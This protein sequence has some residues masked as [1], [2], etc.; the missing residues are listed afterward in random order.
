M[1]L[2]QQNLGM[3]KKPSVCVWNIHD[4][5]M[6]FTKHPWLNRRVL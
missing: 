2:E 6:V 1:I 5:E 3:K 4:G